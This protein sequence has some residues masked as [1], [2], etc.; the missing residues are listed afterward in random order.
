MRAVQP[1]R[2]ALTGGIT[3]GKSLVADAFAG[4]GAPVIDTDVIAHE[5]TQPGST[6]LSRIVAEFGVEMLDAASALDRSKLRARVFEDPAARRS[7][8][9]LLHPAI[10]AE[11]NRRAAAVQAPYVVLVIP[12]LVETGIEDEVDRVLVVDC[13]EDQQLRR[14]RAR[15]G[16]TETSARR[17]LAAQATR[18]DRLAVAD[19]VIDNSGTREATR[20]AVAA[21]HLRYLELAS[22]RAES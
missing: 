4:H 12:L 9:A 22:H 6:A 11:M 7:L 3:C 17:I 14:L 1:M 19:D 15:D 5:I 2:V 18:K 10:V 21:L 20:N 16:E 8:E 13:P